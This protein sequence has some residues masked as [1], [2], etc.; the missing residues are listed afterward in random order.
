[1]DDKKN[2]KMDYIR[3][4]SDVVWVSLY[5][6]IVFLLSFFTLPT[7]TKSLGT[8]LY[9]LWNQILVTVGLLTPILTLHLGTA[10]VRYIAGEKRKDVIS[11]TFANMFWMIIFVITSILI[12]SI[13]FKSI[14]SEIMFNNVIFAPFVILTFVLAGISAIYNFLTTYL[15]ARGRIKQLSIINIISCLLTTT[16]LIILAMLGYSLEFMIYMNLIINFIFV[17]FLLIGIKKEIG[18]RKPNFKNLRKYLAFS[19]PQIP[20]GILLWVMNLSDR[21]FITFF[22][23][24]SQTGI[25]SASYNIG[26]IITAFYMPLNF[27]LYPV[28]SKYWNKGELTV[29]KNY[30]EYSTKI[31]LVFAIPGSV[32]LYVLSEPLLEILTTSE[33]VVGGSLTFFVAVGAIFLGIF[34]NNIYIIYLIEKTKY[35]PLITGTAAILNIAINIILIPQIGIMGA[36]ISTLIAYLILSLIASLWTRR[37]VNYSINPLFLVKVIISSIIMGLVIKYI[38]LASILTILLCIIVGTIVYF[39]CIFS[40]KTLSTTEKEFLFDIIRGSPKLFFDFYQKFIHHIR[41]YFPF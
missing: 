11:Q 14:F 15:R 38:A 6:M 33:F 24:L 7:L 35:V 3:F 23:G 1:M 34:Q 27:V 39:S 4:T 18:L 13:L 32:G 25:Y 40:L 2:N 17:S 22:L 37:V 41:S 19:I 12:I 5:N 28:V 36:A 29:V 31:F 16:S 20:T 9:G 10:T 26:Y 21:Y 30:F 8:E